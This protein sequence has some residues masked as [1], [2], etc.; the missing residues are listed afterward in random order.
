MSKN[1]MVPTLLAP[2]TLRFPSAA[3]LMWLIFGLLCGELGFFNSG[4]PIDFSALPCGTY[5]RLRLSSARKVAV[6]VWIA[7]LLPVDVLRL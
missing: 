1:E 2:R 5:V 4:F 6:D 3:S 7:L